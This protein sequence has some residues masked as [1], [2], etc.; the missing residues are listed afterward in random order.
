MRNGMAHMRLW[1]SYKRTL[2]TEI[3]GWQAVEKLYYIYM[4]NVCPVAEGYG[5]LLPNG[6]PWLAPLSLAIMEILS[7]VKKAAFLEEHAKLLPSVT[8]AAKQP[9]TLSPASSAER[10]SC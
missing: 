3:N 8:A 2:Q 7:P 10:T 9:A 6:E 5:D 1:R 4:I